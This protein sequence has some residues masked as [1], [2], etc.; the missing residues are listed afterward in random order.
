MTEFD[1]QEETARSFPLL[2]RGHQP[3]VADKKRFDSP[4]QRMAIYGLYLWQAGIPEMYGESRDILQETDLCAEAVE[5]V[6]RWG[7]KLTRWVFPHIDHSPSQIAAAGKDSWLHEHVRSCVR[8]EATEVGRA[9][10]GS[11][12]YCR[13]IPERTMV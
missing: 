3:V 8:S 1:A 13:E 4:E 12:P 9:L 2:S 5:R 6:I 10:C 11:G 7:C